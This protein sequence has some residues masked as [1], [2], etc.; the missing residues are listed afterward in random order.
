MNW[1]QVVAIIL[2]ILPIGYHLAKHGQKR[3]DSYNA[4]GR[5]IVATYWAVILYY[6]GFWS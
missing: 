5:M 2:M 6:G 1:Y 4:F 3:D